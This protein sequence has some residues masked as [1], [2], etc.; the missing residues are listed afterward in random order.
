MNKETEIII[1]EWKF[2]VG[3]FMQIIKHPTNNQITC[4]VFI[5]NHFKPEH[6][7]AVAISIQCNHLHC[8]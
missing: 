6:S 1:A 2:I 8:I 4:S 7:E 3:T 5:R